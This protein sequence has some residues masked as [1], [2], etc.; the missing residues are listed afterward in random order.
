MLTHYNSVD[1]R[2]SVEYHEKNNRIVHLS[3]SR[4]KKVFLFYF[5][6]NKIYYC[7]LMQS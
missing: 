6:Q 5:C 7:T 4:F 2:L 1:R 3:M